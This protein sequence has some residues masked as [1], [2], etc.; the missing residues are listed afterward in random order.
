MSPAARRRTVDKGK[1]LLA[2][3]PLTSPHSE[4]TKATVEKLR[5]KQE[6]LETKNVSRQLH[7]T[8]KAVAA[9]GLDPAVLQRVCLTVYPEWKTLRG[10][11]KKAGGGRRGY[12]QGQGLCN[13]R[14]FCKILRK[15][16]GLAKADV[17]AMAHAFFED[18]GTSDGVN[19]TKFLETIVRN[20]ASTK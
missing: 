1:Q 19:Y 20:F 3:Q 16:T 6:E 18:R 2:G 11:L 10:I 17:T 7:L 13:S 8:K 4:I 12:A 5:R 15:K 9:A 14:L